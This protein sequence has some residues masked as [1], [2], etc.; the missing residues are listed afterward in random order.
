MKLIQQFFQEGSGKFSMTRLL[1]FILC[2]GGIV[3]AFYSPENYVGYL[4][5]ITIGMGGKVTQKSIK[6]AEK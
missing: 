4:G 6:M 2:V 5:I 1:S 3:F